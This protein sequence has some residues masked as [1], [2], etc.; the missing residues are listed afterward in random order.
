MGSAQHGVC[1]M[2]AFRIETPEGFVIVD[3]GVKMNPGDEVAFQYDGYPMVGKLFASGLITQ[4][5]ET[6]DGEALDDVE[7]IGV[8]KWLVNRTRDDDAPVM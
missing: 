5:G 4:D 2:S 7:V 1:E 6:I 8:V 3:S